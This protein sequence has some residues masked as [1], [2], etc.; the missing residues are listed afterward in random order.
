[1]LWKFAD[2]IN[3]RVLLKEI[4]SSKRQPIRSI[5]RYFNQICQNLKYIERTWHLVVRSKVKLIRQIDW[6]ISRKYPINPFKL[7]VGLYTRGEVTIIIKSVTNFSERK[8]DI[9][10]FELWSDFEFMSVC[11][12]ELFI[13]HGKF[14]K[15]ETIWNS[16][17]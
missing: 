15:Y 13:G 16:D 4:S 7:R 10:L 5:I 14:A 9:N 3:I 11:Q 1:M 8:V 12:E 6:G 2:I 17:K